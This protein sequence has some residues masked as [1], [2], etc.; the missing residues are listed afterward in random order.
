MSFIYIRMSTWKKFSPQKVTLLTTKSTKVNFLFFVTK[1][2]LFPLRSV[3]FLFSFKNLQTFLMLSKL[4]MLRDCVLFSFQSDKNVG[5]SKRWVAPQQT[6]LLL[7]HLWRWL[8][9]HDSTHFLILMESDSCTGFFLLKSKS[10][11]KCFDFISRISPN[12]KSVDQSLC[13]QSSF[14]LSSPKYSTKPSNYNWYFISF[15]QCILPN[16]T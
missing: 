13:I 3:N 12:E 7:H 5:Y 9:S 11:L 6:W 2:L 8:K 10:I 14:S 15:N 16:L 4:C 1:F